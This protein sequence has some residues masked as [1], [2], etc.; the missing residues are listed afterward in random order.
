[1]TCILNKMHTFFL[2]LL[3][4]IFSTGD[5]FRVT[6]LI[7]RVKTNLVTDVNDSNKNNYIQTC[8]LQLNNMFICNYIVYLYTW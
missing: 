7:Q 1:M 6:E 8:R 3:V 4:E 5:C 2:L